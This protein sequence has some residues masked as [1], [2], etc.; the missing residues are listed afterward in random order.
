MLLVKTILL[1]FQAFTSIRRPGH[2]SDHYPKTPTALIYD[3]SGKHKYWGKKAEK[4]KLK[5]SDKENKFYSLFKLYLHQPNAINLPPGFSSV[6]LISEYLECLHSYVYKVMESKISNLNRKRL[7]YCL[8]VPAIWD[9]QAKASMR[10]AAIRARII[11]RDD[12]PLRLMLISE[13]EAAAIY[14]EKRMKEF[15]LSDKQR[16]MVCDAGGGTVDL[17][18]FELNKDEDG[19]RTLHEVTSSSGDAYGS[20]FVDKNMLNLIKEKLA[21]EGE[22]SRKRLNIIMDTFTI[23]QKVRKKEMWNIFDIHF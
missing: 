21:S 16:F 20:S 12:H 9:D 8:T 23:E 22:L 14:C 2:D 17:I 15:Q 5:L 3:S 18:I 6:K 11:D 4:E 13:P 1:I 7:R 10:E 19:N